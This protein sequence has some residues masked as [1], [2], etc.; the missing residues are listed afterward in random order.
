MTREERISRDFKIRHEILHIRY[1]VDYLTKGVR[2]TPITKGVLGYKC[3]QD[4]IERDKLLLENLE[5][6]QKYLHELCELS[7]E[8]GFEYE[9]EG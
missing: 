2:A 4:I 8:F 3:K 1:M 6:I 7:N 5:G 9:K